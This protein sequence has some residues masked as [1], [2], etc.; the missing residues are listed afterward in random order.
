MPCGVMRPTGVMSCSG[1]P[2]PTPSSAAS[3]RPRSTGGSTA[4]AVGSGGGS[5]GSSSGA[6]G[7][8]G[9][10]SGG[11]AG[12]TGGGSCPVGAQA[13][14][15]DLGVLP[16]AV[17]V[18]GGFV[19]VLVWL[20]GHVSRDSCGDGRRE[21]AGRAQARDLDLGVLPAAVVVVV[22]CSFGLAC[23]GGFGI[24]LRWAGEGAQRRQLDRARDG[25][26][27]VHEFVAALLDLAGQ[28]GDAGV[29]RGVDAEQA[30]ALAAERGAH[31][32]LALEHGAGAG[33]LGARGDAGEQRLVGGKP[34]PSSRATRM[35]AL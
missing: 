18:F 8:P 21:L 15:L 27:V 17:V 1:S 30:G 34:A 11:S 14:D 26:G 16:A 6:T 32:H 22:G 23:S 3:S 5:A 29:A 24:G 9:S 28:R 2:T 25:L 12:G 13:R 20:W 33:D 4:S 19:L 10:T 35:W 31:E 7:V